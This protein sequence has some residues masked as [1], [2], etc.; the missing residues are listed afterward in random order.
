MAIEV[1]QLEW[2]NHNSVRNYPLTSDATAQDTSR[3]FTLPRDFI[4][5]LYVSVHAGHDVQPFLFHLKSLLV[6]ASGYSITVG[7]NGEDVAAATIYR[8]THERYNTYVMGGLGDFRD[9]YGYVTIGQ[10]DNIDLQ[11]SGFFQFD[12]EDGRL[13]PDAIRPNIR[14]LSSIRVQS[15]GDLSDRIYGDIVL[16]AGR[17]VRIVPIVVAGQDPILQFDAI[18]G[19]GLNTAPECSSP[20]DDRVVKNINGVRPTADGEFFLQGSSCLEVEAIDNGL[21]LIDVCSEPCC[22]SEELKVITEAMERLAQQAATLE[23]FVTRLESHAS[24]MD[25]LVLGS[26]FGDRGCTELDNPELPE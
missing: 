24:S 22:G 12:L 26:K 8:A 15:G 19:E 14:S 4:V 1:R 11:P 23:R 6:D 20:E 13:E 17:N 5:G 2:L 10:L 7:Y 18:S 25:Q 3:S 16:R 21:R 9:A